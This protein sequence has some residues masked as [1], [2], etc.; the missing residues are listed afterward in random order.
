MGVEAGKLVRR[1]QQKYNQKMVM[2]WTRIEGHDERPSDSGCVSKVKLTGFPD[3]L[4]VGFARK[5]KNTGNYKDFGPNIWPCLWLAFKYPLAVRDGYM[6]LK[7]QRW[8]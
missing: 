5:K 8:D 3:E 6:C 2:A 4:Y 1:L 7:G